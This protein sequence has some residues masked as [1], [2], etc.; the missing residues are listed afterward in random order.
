MFSNL[1]VTKDTM[2]FLH[3]K[4]Y[5]SCKNLETLKRDRFCS[6]KW[7]EI[8]AAFLFRNFRFNCDK[9][10]NMFAILFQF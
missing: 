5:I 2:S 8:Y 3:E 10:K 6:S 1:N 4:R 7:H 9:L